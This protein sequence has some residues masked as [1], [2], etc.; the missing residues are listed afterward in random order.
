MNAVP[1]TPDAY[2]LQRQSF[3][4]L[5]LSHHTV[6]RWH[7]CYRFRL[8]RR[9][10]ALCAR[11]L[12]I[13]PAM[14]LTL[15]VGQLTGR[16]PAWA[17]WGILMLL[18]LPAVLDWATTT[19]SGKPERKNWIRTLTGAGLGMGIG[20]ALHVNSYALLNEPVAAQ[21]LYIVSSVLLVRLWVYFR[22]N[23]KRARQARARLRN[24]PTLLEY[25]QK[26]NERR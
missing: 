13:V 9:E 12:G 18:P 5:L 25:I 7:L 14:I 24:R 6:D 4:S 21:F 1:D 16:W 3:L 8:G 23:L 20:G 19:V 2:L 17:E 26:S 10:V 11:C 15:I 22:V